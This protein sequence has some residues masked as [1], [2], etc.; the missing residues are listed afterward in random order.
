MPLIMDLAR[1]E[2][3]RQILRLMLSRQEMG[4]PFMAPPDLPP[5]RA[6]ALRAAFE[7]P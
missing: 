7:P 2:R 6:A 5:E 1:N 3:E 4:W